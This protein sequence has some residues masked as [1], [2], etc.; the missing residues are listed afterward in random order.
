MPQKRNAKTV[1]AEAAHATRKEKVA[2]ADGEMPQKRNDGRVAK[3]EEEIFQKRGGG[4][5]VEAEAAAVTAARARRIAG[6]RKIKRGA[7]LGRKMR[8]QVQV[9]CEIGP[10]K[11]PHRLRAFKE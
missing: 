7:L 11:D 4:R 1:E 10:R 8:G 6:G 9:L 2:K 3:A 5:V